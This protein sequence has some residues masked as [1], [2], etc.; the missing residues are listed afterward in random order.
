MQAFY[1]C[2][3]CFNIKKYPAS[4]SIGR[5]VCFNYYIFLGGRPMLMIVNIPFE[6]FPEWVDV[7]LPDDGFE[8]LGFVETSQIGA[9]ALDKRFEL[10]DVL[11]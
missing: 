6:Q 2:K 1:H 8:C 7:F 5:H 10:F 4:A 11:W 9:K 3:N